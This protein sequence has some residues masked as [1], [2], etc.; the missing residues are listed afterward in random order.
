MREDVISLF[1]QVVDLPLA[2]RMDYYSSRQVPPDVRDEVESLLRFDTHTKWLTGQ[3]A[4]TAR[5]ILRPYRDAAEGQVLGRYRVVRLLGRGGM[6]AVYLAERSDGEVEQQVALKV[7]HSS[8]D[9]PVFQEAFLRE[10]RILASLNHPGIARLL[11]AGH[12]DEGQS[13][14]VMEYVDGISIE[15][16]CASLS[17][18]EILKL[19]LAV[20]A[21]VAYAHRNLIVHRDLKPSNILIDRSGTP[22]LLDFGIAKILDASDQGRTAVRLL[23]PEYASP[24]Q[25][26]GEAHSTATDI[27]S[28]G[29][30]LYK[31]L[32]GSAPNAPDS[33]AHPAVIPPPSRS[34]PGIPTDIDFI[35]QKALR[36]EPEE[37]YA[38]ADAL[39][40]DLGAFLEN[41]PVRARAGNAWYLARKFLR[42]YWIP[43]SAA[44]V[45]LSGLSVGLFIANRE[46]IVAQQRFSQVRD[47]SN[48]VF[49]L[50]EEIRGLPGATK[51]RHALVALS[52]Q[53]LERLGRQAH[54]DKDLALEIGSAYVSVAEVQG[55]PGNSN[56]GE[57][58]SAD[59]S[60][61]KADAMVDPILAVAP[62]DR[63]ALLQSAEIAHDRMIVSDALRQPDRSLVFAQRSAA[64]LDTVLSLG[65]AGN[66]AAAIGRFYGNIALAHTNRHRLDDAVSYARRGVESTRGANVPYYFA[67]ALSILANALRLRGDLEESLKTTRE[68]RALLE[69]QPD[70]S[71][72]QNTLIGVTWREGRILG[73]D[74]EINLNR[75][76]EAIAA[77][78]LA[79]DLSDQLARRDA[80]DYASRARFVAAARDLGGILRHSDP[81]RALAVYDSGLRRS[82]E[83]KNTESAHDRVRLL[84]DSSYPLLALHRTAEAKQRIDAA[85]ELLRTMNLWPAESLRPADDGVFALRALADYNADIGRRQDAIDA[86]REL[87]QKIMASK[88]SPTTDLQDA[89]S[90]SSIQAAF[91]N[92]ERK[93]GR[94][95]EAIELERS[96]RELWQQWDKKLPNN[97]FVRRQLAALP[98]N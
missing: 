79:Y 67:G 42:R 31:L 17:L 95:G 71:T 24:E 34:K 96:R 10:R 77:L 22:K 80:A 58:N 9:L 18:R 69:Q 83:I 5:E 54:G 3:I 91:S 47:L 16:Y 63:R 65:P 2:I 40:E 73:G 35:V 62:R 39:A 7:V 68:A 59:E 6:G 12:T 81:V 87:I 57:L 89:N 84:A 41:R 13:Y 20:C 48:H 85:F 86:Y 53:Y 98:S 30:V 92:L 15:E 56:L 19:F 90:I 78:Q 60:L 8:T 27:Y 93:A 66:D 1:H 52:L 74:D 37:R 25:M 97:S 21:A 88:P 45:A 29:A 44:A 33:E 23:T 55:V 38:T 28:L 26:R 70:D 75:P 32:T 61:A 36:R 43:V 50:D 49:K 82:A 46:R 51:A 94:A 11:D 72:R 64:R 76:A 14:L 4:E